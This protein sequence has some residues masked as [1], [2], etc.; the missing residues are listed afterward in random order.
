MKTKLTLY[1]LSLAVLT[2]CGGGG[3]GISST[4]APLSR[5][6]VQYT[7]GSV[8]SPNT[9]YNNQALQQE[10]S[11]SYSLNPA[12]DNLSILS[13]VA[14]ANTSEGQFSVGFDQNTNLDY[15]RVISGSVNTDFSVNAAEG[16]EID[17]TALGQGSI[18]EAYTA[19]GSSALY[20]LT[21][22]NSDYQTYGF[23]LSNRIDGSGAGG[24]FTA[25]SVTPATNLPASGVFSYRGQSTGLY[26]TGDGT[27]YVTA[28]KVSLT[29]FFDTRG[30][31]GTAR[32]PDVTFY[33]YDTKGVN[34]N[35]GAT[36][37]LLEATLLGDLKINNAASTFTGSLDHNGLSGAANGRFYGPLYE[38][39]GGVFRVGGGSVRYVGSFGASR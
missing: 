26:T 12:T 20:F 33:S 37:S 13:V 23:W 38:E 27:P 17:T 28:S 9:I 14:N 25:G 1:G 24:A 36:V 2:A 29:A 16:G 35:T 3:G 7:G 15:L 34:V 4:L 6:T 8:F 11:Y 21:P 10:F 39:V 30:V 5:T 32:T 18:G 19:D 22:D 31:G